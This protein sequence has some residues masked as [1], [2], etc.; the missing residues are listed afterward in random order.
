MQFMRLMQ[1]KYRYN[2]NAW[3]AVYRVST[4]R[5]LLKSLREWDVCAWWEKQSHGWTATKWDTMFNVVKKLINEDEKC[6]KA[7]S[8]IFIMENLKVKFL[9]VKAEIEETKKPIEQKTS[10]K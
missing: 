10:A 9:Q 2:A 1:S 8:Y 7:I 6:L 5:A 4:E 3:N